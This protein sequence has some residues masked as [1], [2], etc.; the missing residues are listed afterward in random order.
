MKPV[1]FS[2]TKIFHICLI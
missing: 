1:P 2:E